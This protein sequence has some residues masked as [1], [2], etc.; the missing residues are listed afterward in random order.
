MG[1]AV[2]TASQP[3]LADSK[4]QQLECSWC[5]HSI[6]LALGALLDMAREKM[7]HILQLDKLARLPR[8]HHSDLNLAP[9]FSLPIAILEQCTGRRLYEHGTSDWKIVPLARSPRTKLSP[10]HL[11]LCTSSLS[12]VKLFPSRVR[13]R[14]FYCRQRTRLKKTLQMSAMIGWITQYSR[15]SKI[16]LTIKEML[17]TLGTLYL[18]R[19]SIEL[20]WTGASLLF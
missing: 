9:I 15:D 20:K 18:C 11:F 13:W 2:A 8:F 12:V 7:L 14:E 5:R 19:I 17:A 1:F 6:H 4:L 16:S 3:L 10:R